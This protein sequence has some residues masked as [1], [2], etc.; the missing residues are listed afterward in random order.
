[1]TE[2]TLHCLLH[3]QHFSQHRFDL[4]NSVKSVLDNFESL[5]DNDK[6]DILLYGIS[7]LGNKKNKFMLE[8]TLNYIKNSERFSGFLFE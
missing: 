2:G 4:L 7:R 8:A 3:C 5:F 1:M 6:K